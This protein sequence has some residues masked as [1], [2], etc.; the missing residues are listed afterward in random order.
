MCFLT[1][2]NFK[3]DGGYLRLNDRNLLHG[4]RD[5]AR[6]AVRRDFSS[7]YLSVVRLVCYLYE[8]F[9]DSC[10]E[11]QKYRG[12]HAGWPYQTLHLCTAS[13][14]LHVGRRRQERQH[15]Y[16]PLVPP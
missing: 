16:D 14:E 10:L 4:N 11:L 8:L 12:V 3:D 1:V 9:W 15:A 13:K 7:D 5:C 2:Y 6:F